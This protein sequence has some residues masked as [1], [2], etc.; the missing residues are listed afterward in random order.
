LPKCSGGNASDVW[1]QFTAID[2]AC[3]V[4][5]KFDNST[6]NFDVMTGNCASPTSI[7][8][9]SSNGSKRISNLSI[10]TTYF[11]RCYPSNF[12]TR[13]LFTI[14]ITGIP[15]ND[16]C[17]NAKTINTSATLDYSDPSNNGLFEAAVSLPPCSTTIY[18]KDVWYQFTAS[19]ATAAIIS[20][21]DAPGG[22]AYYQVYSG[23][24]ATL[25]SLSC[26]SQGTNELHKAL[27]LSNLIPSQTYYIRQYGNKY[28]TSLSVVNPPAN[29]LIS[30]AIQLNPSPG[31]VQKF[32]SYSLHGAGKSFGKICNNLSGVPQH[33]VWFYFIAQNASHNVSI[34]SF[35]SFW[36]EQ[37][38]GITYRMEAFKGYAADSLNLSIKKL[39]CTSTPFA[40][41]GLTVGDTIYLRVYNISPLGTTTIF[42]I[43]VNNNQNIDEPIGALT[44]DAIND[45]QYQL[46]TTGATQ[47]LPPANCKTAEFSDDDVWL[48]FTH[49][50][51]SKRVIA[52]YENKDIVLEL[53]SGTPGSL[54]SLFCSNNIMVLPTNLSVGAQYYVRAY[55]KA[56]AQ[57]ATFR[58]GLFD[59]GNALSN[60][61]FNP[62]QLGMNLVKNPKCESNYA[63]LPTSTTSGPFFTG[64]PLAKDWW[65]S[66]NST[67]DIWDA[68]YP[69]TF[70]GSIPDA[71]FGL[72]RN[73]I[74]HSGKGVLGMLYQA[75]V[76]WSEYVT[77]DLTQPLVKGKSYLVSFYV[78]MDEIYV[79]PLKQLGAYLSTS[80]NFGP[81]TDELKF[82]PHISIPQTNPLVVDKTWRNVCGII[83]ADLAYK[84]IT[85]GNFG[86]KGL[87][88]D[89][90][91]NGYIYVDDVFVGEIPDSLASSINEASQP[92]NFNLAKNVSAKLEAFP[93]P[94]NDRLTVKW[95]NEPN[96]KRSQIII[97]DLNVRAV[98]QSEVF[99]LSVTE[100]NINLQ[101]IPAGFYTISLIGD[102]KSAS[103]KLII[104]R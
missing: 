94:A 62:A 98:W 68:D 12:N 37:N 2:T 90:G 7:L 61:C 14:G 48:K 49:G 80:R 20:H 17:V 104:A 30:G 24:C 33:D 19:S 8:C 23:N 41:T 75:G 16:A 47:T 66:G 29:D 95:N 42:S 103:T 45:Y 85:L 32:P 26:F 84:Y 50:T 71:A 59:D 72:G 21:T 27:T 102:G 35:N 46:S 58:I 4:D 57:A 54:T 1:Y 92:F 78:K 15:N 3:Y 6:T 25:N 87:Y 73:I 13:S 56:N 70:W 52:G 79:S 82:T 76:A 22:D 91:K 86:D 55:S 81:V 93:N 38:T 53:F 88:G 28:T 39:P 10:G 83:K 18:T 60:T 67:P 44:L 36:D 63:L 99:P 65:I 64:A 11:I 101:K 40:L 97:N 69:S 89:F 5:V 34:S 9:A 51:T 31:S 77:G 74:P 96:N 100:I 43:N